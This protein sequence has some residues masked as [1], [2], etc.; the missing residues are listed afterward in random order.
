MK[1]MKTMILAGLGIL[2]SA[3]SSFSAPEGSGGISQELKALY[4]KALLTGGT[5]EAIRK[6]LDAA[7]GRGTSEMIGSLYLMR[8]NLALKAGDEE[9]ALSDFLKVTTLFQKNKAIQ[10]EALF[11]AATLLDAAR[12]PRGDDL[13][14]SLIRDYPGNEFA[15]KAAAA[16]KLSAPQASP[17]P[18]KNP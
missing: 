5:N 15:L 3:G 8:G 1:T 17:A 13:R 4:Q 10:P 2:V 12:D 11:Q 16:P 18:A 7:I 14:K 6:Q 9:A